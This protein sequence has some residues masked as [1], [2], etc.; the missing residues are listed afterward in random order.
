MKFFF[1]LIT[2]LST[3]TSSCP[4]LTGKYAN[5][6]S[7]NGD[8]SNSRNAI[9]SQNIENGITTFKVVAQDSESG[10][11][12]TTVM[13]SDGKVRTTTETDPTSGLSVTEK[14]SYV[15]KGNELLGTLEM[16]VGT[17]QVMSLKI[18]ALKK[19]NSVTIETKGSAIDQ[20]IDDLVICQ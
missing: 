11:S 12:N 18:K 17:D 5:C 19:G 10:E 14:D 6:I 16:F 3:I 9:F 20:T 15:C 1:V 8:S 4:N 2:L 13:I 7:Q